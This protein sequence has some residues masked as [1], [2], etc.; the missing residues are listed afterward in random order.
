MIAL[1]NVSKNFGNK[2]L[3]EKI[4]LELEQGKIYGFVGKNGTG[5]TVLF[6]MISG[7]MSPSSG[8]IKVSNLEIGKDVDFPENCGLI[9]ESPGFVNNLSGYKNVKMLGDIRGVVTE[10][11][12]KKYF[13]IFKLDPEDKKKVK[14]YSLGMKQKIGLIQAFMEDPKI[15][16]LDEPMK[17]I[18]SCY[19]T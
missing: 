3:F 1:Q 19:V 16:I 11:E 5:K 10:E 14:N 4:N 15:L 17:M 18:S 9:I 8:K 7:F 13:S 2:I 6:K 12:I